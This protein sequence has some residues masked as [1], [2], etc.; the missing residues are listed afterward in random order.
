MKLKNQ[1]KLKFFSYEQLMMVD[2]LLP[3]YANIVNFL[4]CKVLPSELSSQQR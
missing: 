2:T 1:E 4:S 3:W